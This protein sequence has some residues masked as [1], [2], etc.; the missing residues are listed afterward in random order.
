MSSV[1]NKLKKKTEKYLT[2]KCTGSWESYGE[3]QSEYM[4]EVRL[5]VCESIDKVPGLTRIRKF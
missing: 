3:A 1:L 4:N 2:P 5:T